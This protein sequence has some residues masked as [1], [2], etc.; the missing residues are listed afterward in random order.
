MDSLDNGE[1]DLVPLPVSNI[2]DG[3]ADLHN[4]IVRDEVNYAL[5][6]LEEVATEPAVFYGAVRDLFSE[7]GYELPSFE[8]LPMN[9]DGET[10]ESLLTFD[11]P[12]ESK[13]VCCYLYVAFSKEETGFD[14]LAELVNEDELEILLEL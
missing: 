11:C 6:N 4:D 7:L 14:V 12:H 2:V 9:R 10:G 5:D 13:H 3:A 8:Q 1:G